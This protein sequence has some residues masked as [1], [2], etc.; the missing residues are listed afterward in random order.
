MKRGLI[1]ALLC[2]ACVGALGRQASVERIR[3]WAGPD[4][5]RVVFDLS[6][7]VEYRLF[8]LDNPSRAVLD[9]QSTAL[10]EDLLESAE[11]VGVLEGI[12][13]AVRNGNDLRMVFDLAQAARLK[14]FLVKPNNTYGNRLVVD[15][16][17]PQGLREP[18]K[19]LAQQPR[20]L[21]VAIDAGHGGGDPGAIG[22][23][24]TFEKTITLAI[25]QK[26]A[27]LIST[28]SNMR[29]VLTR[30]G[31]YYVGLRE[32]TR[33][34]RQ[35]RADLFISIHADSIGDGRAQGASVYVL[36]RNGASTEAARLLAQRENSADRIGGVSLDG[37][38]DVVATV[39]VD[40]SRAATIESSTHLAQSMLAV[41]NDVGELHK[42]S[43]ERAGFAVLKSLDM[44]S[45]L[46][47]SAFISN[48]REELRLRSSR[49][50][51]KLARALARGVGDYI[52]EFMPGRRIMVSAHEYVVR[53]G[54]TL[55]AIAQE[56]NVSVKQLRKL[57]DLNGDLLAI[58][59]RLVIP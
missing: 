38:D 49:F 53:R 55:S 41:L 16:E 48:P 37:K 10:S 47:E 25:A 12:R 15:F 51:W 9:I 56:H 32:R 13:G 6:Q 21:V 31:D 2:C 40:L 24:G 35:A 18:V 54:D 5:T 44:P 3:T 19:T 33:L 20:E 34:A 28:R 1:F 11:P 36:S 39:L 58:G 17:K 45:V 52:E 23:H 57:N 42:S 29:A 4:H 7:P 22:Q 43:V 26:L 30:K 50:Q 27:E 14:S 46:V 8:T 59:S